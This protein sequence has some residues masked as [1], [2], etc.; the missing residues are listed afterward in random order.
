[1]ARAALRPRGAARRRGGPVLHPGPAGR[2]LPDVRPPRPRGGPGRQRPGR[3]ARRAR[4]ARGSA[5]ARAERPRRAT[6]TSRNIF[7]YDNYPGGI[8]LSEP[9]YRLHDRLLAREP[10]AD[11]GLRLPRRLPVLRRAGGRGG[12]PRQGSGAR[13]PASGARRDR[14]RRNDPQSPDEPSMTGS[15]GCR[16]APRRLRR[17]RRARRRRR[18]AARAPSCAARRSAPGPPTTT[19]R[20]R[21]G[22]SG[23]WRRPRGARRAAPGRGRPAPRRAARTAAGWRTSAAS[24]SSSKTT[25]TWR[26]ATATCRS[27]L[28]RPRSGRR[29]HPDRRARSSG[30]FD[31][32]RAVFLDTE[33]TGLA[34]GTGTAAFLIGRGLRR[35]RPLPRAAVLHA[36][37]PRGGGAAARAGRGPRAASTAS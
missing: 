3:G 14:R 2:A 23:W 17:L 21:S 32:R 13:H 6:T 16:R 5:A 31:L 34:G 33:T 20:S 8:G 37:L 30:A 35:R 10:G 19:L 12:Q 22:W 27:P 28:P 26:P 36:R 24:S 1:M 4:P 29:L 25:S 18:S 15:S 9:L 7:I 11:R